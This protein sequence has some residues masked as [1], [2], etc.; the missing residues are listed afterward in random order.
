WFVSRV[1]PLVRQRVPDAR[2]SMI[3]FQPTAA[4]KALASTEG[5]TLYANLRDLRSEARSHAIAVLPFVSGAGIK[6]K[7]L[8]A[9]ALGLPIVSTPAAAEGLRGQP[10]L[11]LASRP[12]EFAN[13]I[14]GLWAD[15]DR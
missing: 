11:V 13:A 3:G 5:V 15:A 1:W 9:A 14:V 4:V 10:P 12:D 8:E 7:L 2:F 6:N